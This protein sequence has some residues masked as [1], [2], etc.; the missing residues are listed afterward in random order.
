MKWR[1]STIPSIQFH[2]NNS[3]LDERWKGVQLQVRLVQ[4]LARFNVGFVAMRLANDQVASTVTGVQPDFG[5]GA[6]NACGV[7]LIAPAVKH[8]GHILYFCFDA[9]VVRDILKGEGF[10]IPENIQGEGSV[11]HGRGRPIRFQRPRRN[12]LKSGNHGPEQPHPG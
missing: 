5:V 7:N 8:E 4:A 10:F 3:T 9:L 2:P 6:I 11:K 1:D 12:G